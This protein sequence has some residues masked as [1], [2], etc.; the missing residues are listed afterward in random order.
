MSVR[1][2]RK[3]VVGA[4]VAAAIIV[5]AA[6]PAGAAPNLY[7]VAPLDLGG[8]SGTAYAV[9]VVGN[10]AYIG[11]AFTAARRYTQSQPRVNLMAIN[12]AANP[13]S[14]SLSLP[15]RMIR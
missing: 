1:L 5:S 12:L 10:T 4:V 2:R 6:A 8:Q 7:P 9:E 13:P 15:R 14:N 3:A 11:G